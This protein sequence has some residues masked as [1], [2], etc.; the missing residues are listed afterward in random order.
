MEQQDNK[1][2]D[3][4]IQW[5]SVGVLLWLLYFAFTMFTTREQYSVFFL[6]G[7]YAVCTLTLLRGKGFPWLKG[8]WRTGLAFLLF[9]TTI[10]P[11]IYLWIEYDD[12]VFSRLSANTTTDYILAAVFIFPA[13]ILCWKEGGPILGGI[14]AFFL[15]YF[16]AGP[17]LPGLFHHGGMS[18]ARVLEGLVLDFRGITGIVVKVVGT[19]VAIFIMYAGLLQG[20]GLM[21]TILKISSMLVKKFKY[22]LPQLPVITSLFFGSI[23]GAAA[24]NVAATGSF[25]I[26]LMKRFGFPPK[27]AGAIE[28]VAST[29]GQ[30][31][32]PIMGATAF[33]MATF[34]GKPYYIIMLVGFI[35]AL[36]FYLSVA[37]SVHLNSLKHLKVTSFEDIT[38][39]ELALSIM[40]KL[41]LIP[42]F[43]SLAVILLFLIYFRVDVLRAGLFGIISFLVCQFLLELHRPGKRM[44]LDFGQN[45]LNG[46]RI[47]VLSLATIGGLA[48]AMGIIIKGMTATALAPKISF[49][50]IDIAAGSVFLLLFLAMLVCLVFGM[51]VSTLVVYILVAL[52]VAPALV[53][54]GIPIMVS[55]FTIFYFGIL[56]MITPPHAS[57]VIVASGIAKSDF[58][59]T[60]VEAMKLGLPLLLLP[61]AFI[62][63]P[64]IIEVSLQTLLAVPLVAIGLLALSY[65]FYSPRTGAKPVLL[66]VVCGIGGGLILFY[67][68]KIV[69]IS[70]AIV[71]ILLSAINIFLPRLRAR[72]IG[73]EGG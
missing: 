24:A 18:T 70:I 43:V 55:H 44:L 54:F 65:A 32:P 47:G 52:F 41:R 7:I 49:L 29:G 21:D 42:V 2:L 46:S 59:A 61:F 5:V 25:T 16:Y 20:F 35:P 12:L 22:A 3:R 38:G 4:A 62:T 33:V 67:P 68:V 45:L 48:G 6:M 56:A 73:S 63:Y 1:A 69:A 10:V 19:W 66:R 11:A 71:L 53:Q 57:A 34:L 72:S 50:M 17:I 30:A 40:E 13:M 36:L 8:R 64:E 31:M 58:I 39:E 9:A 37:F 28:S 60:A 27:I 14:V 26:P 51:A 15:L 23:S